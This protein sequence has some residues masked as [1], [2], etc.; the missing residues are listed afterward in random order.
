MNEDQ[1]CRI[2]SSVF[3]SFFH[4]PDVKDH[5]INSQSLGGPGANLARKFVLTSI[6]RVS[7]KWFE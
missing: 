6:I 7:Y 4:G 3:F 2:I 1:F 5:V